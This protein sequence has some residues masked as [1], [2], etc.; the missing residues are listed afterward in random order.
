MLDAAGHGI[1]AGL[2]DG[3][4]LTIIGATV[5]VFTVVGIGA[6][7][8]QVRWLS[9]EAD[10]SLLK[11]TINL[12]LPC[13]IFATVADN[14]A[15]REA[16]NLVLSPIVGFG[17]LVLG[18]AAGLLVARLGGRLSGLAGSTQR[19]TFAL[20]VG[21]YNYGFLPVPLV[22]VIFDDQTLGVLFVHNVG[23]GL[24]L[25]TIGVMLLSG[26][27]GRGWWR[28]MVNP[29]AIAVAVALACNFLGVTADLPEFLLKPIRWLGEATVPMA[30]VLVGATIADQLR[31][32]AKAHGRGR[33]VKVIAW[34]VLLRLGLLPAA[35]LAVAAVLPASQELKSVI[36]IEAAMP[37]AV[38]PVLLA[39]HYGGDP[40]TALR[41]V[42]STSLVSLVTI[43][44]WISAGMWWLGLSGAG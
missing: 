35:F 32:R 15:L 22:K 10:Q 44:L 5:S 12:L 38:F 28:Q 17:T 11:L 3:Q 8:R 4:W 14:P 39:R 30:L 31:V 41:V 2:M 37:S 36:V 7:V 29:P 34:S 9:E 18:L 13:L 20:S 40:A 23:V 33:G 42:L 19:R 26:A 16:G 6:A 43:P 27:A 25:W 24:A 1:L 21:T